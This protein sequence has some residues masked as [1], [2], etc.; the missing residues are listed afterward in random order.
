K[1]N[2]LDK[3]GLRKSNSNTA[4][5]F[6]NKASVMAKLT[7]TKDLPS[8]LMLDVIKI[9]R[10]PSDFWKK[11]RFVRKALNCSAIGVLD[12]LLI[13]MLLS[14][15]CGACI[16]SPM[17]AILVFEVMS[18]FVRIRTLSRSWIYRYAKGINKPIRRQP[19]KIIFRLGLIGIPLV[20]GLSIILAWEIL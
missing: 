7:A 11:S 13:T 12:S 14:S 8:P 6:P 4:T 20:R 17:T 18:S 10:Q 19:S 3:V 1:P 16:I 2:F 9:V 5:F 15:A